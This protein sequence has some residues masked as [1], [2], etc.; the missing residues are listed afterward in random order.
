MVFFLVFLQS[1]LYI[2]AILFVCLIFWFVL[3]SN[4]QQGSV[5][6]KCQMRK[7]K[8]IFWKSINSLKGSESENISIDRTL[9]KVL[10]YLLLSCYVVLLFDSDR[11]S[12]PAKNVSI[13]N[14]AVRK[15]LN[16]LESNSKQLSIHSSVILQNIEYTIVLTPHSFSQQLSILLL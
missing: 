14:W 2:I 9:K 15:N 10:Y 3:F 12:S 7:I 6:K 11:R 13:L 16:K 5:F 1:Y 8:N 4:V